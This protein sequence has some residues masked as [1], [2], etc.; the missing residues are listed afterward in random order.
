MRKMNSVK[1]LAFS[2]LLV[3]A[4]LL[5]SSC[6]EKASPTPNKIEHAVGIIIVSDQEQFQ[7]EK[8]YADFSD[9][10][11][12]YDLDAAVVYYFD[13]D[14]ETAYAGGQNV[15]S[16]SFGADVDSRSVGAA[17]TVAFIGNDDPTNMVVTAYYLYF[18]EKGV[19]FDSNKPFANTALGEGVVIEG[20]DYT[21]KITLTSGMPVEYFTV[22]SYQGSTEL[23]SDTFNPKNLT[24]YDKYDLPAQTDRVE[25]V[26]FDASDGIIEQR[27]FHNGERNFVVEYDVGGQIMG[28]K[29]LYLMW[30]D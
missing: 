9:H 25:I 16:L 20:S 22:T 30:S 14:S 7:G 1:L 3:S 12:T 29:T 11:Y 8:I 15:T 4:V 27:T 13:Y 28:A 5:M 24:D 6:G 23:R 2:L 18:D 26:S 21:A 17:A 10:E 19:Y